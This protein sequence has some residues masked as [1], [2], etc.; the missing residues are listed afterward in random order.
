MLVRNRGL[1]MVTKL[2]GK[3]SDAPAASPG[4]PQTP[5]PATVPEVA[6]THPVV[7]QL[8]HHVNFP[9]RV[10]ALQTA[11]VRANVAGPV[12]KV[13]V[14]LGAMVKQ[15]N[16]LFEI[17]PAALPGRSGEMPGR[18]RRRESPAGSGNDRVQG[19]EGALARRPPA[20]GRGGRGLDSGPGGIESRQPQPGVHAGDG[21]DPRQDRPPAG[22]RWEPCEPS[23]K[24]GHDQLAG[25]GVRGLRCRPAPRSSDSI[26]PAR[27]SW[28]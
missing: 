2:K 8:T 9:G 16:V 15:G 14:T 20:H 28:G 13:F 7:R 5:A 22:R 25:S 3:R 24:L 19:S 11:V 18:S 6:V 10:E 17:N 21:D 27:E 4:V 12:T 1:L 26:A 23:F